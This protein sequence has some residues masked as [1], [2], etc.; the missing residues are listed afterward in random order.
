MRRKP[1]YR[2]VRFTEIDAPGPEYEFIIDGLLT[3]NDKSIIGGPSGSGKSFLALHA[4]MSISLATL[5]PDWT[6]FGR[7]VLKP[8]LVIYQ[9]GEGAIGIRKRVRAFRRHF[10]LD[11][12]LDIPFVLIQ[13]PVDLYNAEGDTKPLIEEI[14]D[15]CSDYPDIPL[16]AVFIDTLATATGGADENSGRDMGAVMKNID[17][18]RAA[19]GANICLVHHLNAAGT[20]L[21]GHTSI[22]ANIDQ[23]LMV[24]K[25]ETTGVRTLK[26]GKQ[27]DDDDNLSFQFELMSVG[28]GRFRGFDAK[29]ETSCVCVEL[30][31]KAVAEKTE[32]A[33][34]FRLTP[35]EEGL[36]R[37]FWQARER[38]GVLATVEQEQELGCPPGTILVHYT[39]WR[40]AYASISTPNEDGTK[41]SADAIRKIWSRHHTGLVKFNVLKLANPFMWWEG[42]H[43]R[44]FPATRPVDISEPTYGH[45]PDNDGTTTGQN[46]DDLPF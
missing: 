36:F 3:Q 40:D 43:V 42:K 29:A 7:R 6:F 18:L 45:S 17:I 21:R 46:P 10:D 13:S 22:F 19:T 39:D 37:A 8:G 4:A 12:N 2:R 23:V 16:S 35:T 30:G 26:L 33:K 20:K 34:G 5:Q 15:I 24:A 1:R 44:S 27:K 32:A 41:P 9:A 25:N 38:R 31:Q 11:P 14:K 28:T